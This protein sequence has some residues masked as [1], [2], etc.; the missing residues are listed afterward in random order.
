MSKYHFF[1]YSPLAI[2][3]ALLTSPYSYAN[4]SFVNAPEQIAV[5][6]DV[7]MGEWLA[8]K[9]NQS[10]T[11][12]YDEATVWLSVDEKQKQS[13]EQQVL[14]KNLQQFSTQKNKQS[15]QPLVQWISQ[16]P[17]TGRVL[18]PNQDPYYLQT[19]PSLDPVFKQGDQVHLYQ[20]PNVVSVL[21]DD[22]TAC[23]VHYEAGANAQDYIK[24]CLTQLKHNYTSDVAYLI[25]ANGQVEKLNIAHWNAKTA[26][27]I[28][29]GA[30]IWV[31]KREHRWSNDLAQRVANSIAYQGIALALPY[32]QNE[33]P[34]Q[35]TQSKNQ[36]RDLPVSASDWG[37][38]G[39][40]QTPTAR[41]QKTGT[42]GLHIAHIDPYTNY[43]I[44]LQPFERLEVAM[45][46]TNIDGVSYGRVSPDQDYKDKSLDVKLKLLKESRWT[47]EVAV[48][49]R[50]PVGTSLFGGE[51]VVAN[52]RWK[53]FDFSLGLGWGYLGHRGN[54]DNPLG[55]VANR[56]KDRTKATVGQGGEASIDT[57]FTGPTSLFGGVQWHSP[58]QPLSVKVEYDGNDY[59]NEAHGKKYEADLPVNFGLTWQGRHAEVNAGFERGNTW[60][61]GVALRGDLT[62]LGQYK[63][64]TVPLSQQK[65]FNASGLAYSVALGKLP[66]DLSD[67][68]K[69]LE[70]FS[71]ETNWKASELSYQNGVLLIKAEDD[72]GEFVNERL[73]KG[74]EV[75]NHIAPADTKL[76]TIQLHRYG[77]PI[78]DF[79]IRPA[80]WKAQNKQLLPTVK[81]VAQPFAQTNATH[82]KTPTNATV[83]KVSLPK[84][85]VSVSPS[86]SQS[87]GGP[88][89]YILGVFANANANY[90]LWQGAWLNGTA[91]VRI[92]DNY[93]SYNFNGFS[94]LPQVRTNI[95]KYMTT[96]RVLMPNLQLTQFKQFGQ[97]LYGLAY[98]G[99]L[100]PMFAGVGGEVLY[101]PANKNWAI[102][103]DVN[104]VRQRDFDQHFG[105]QDYDVTTGHL[106]LYWNTNFY[107]I[108]AKLSVGQYLAGD[109]GA[110]LDLSR[111]F[112]N[113]VKMG[114]W[115]TKTN[116]SAEQFGEGSFDKGIYVSIPF[117]AIFKQWSSGSTKLVYQPLLRDGG[118]QINRA[119]T[120][121]DLTNTAGKRSL[122]IQNPLQS[123]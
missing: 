95:R 122:E 82:R 101:R 46:Y 66:K 86:I 121:Y 110:T 10:A 108:D 56:F 85:Y 76:I 5:A 99:Y 30:W 81:Q 39:L 79:S 23:R 80:E 12:Y 37:L 67:T 8:Q 106:S 21:F 77:V 48:G 61:L 118:A 64:P 27:A 50:D 52:K 41:M 102:G 49:W 53:D 17:V 105:L 34:I 11:A 4:S 32:G 28:Q 123:H 55:A 47:P 91:Q 57:W 3:I 43:N 63:K 7:R 26:S 97:G 45:R 89:G 25:Q 2:A 62:Q 93:D 60:M 94:N 70:A 103:L 115:A 59:K 100:D 104:Q 22:A 117:D 1:T 33:A 16:L 18:L 84:G 6:K 51:Y 72:G 44:V 42:A 74:S 88:D 73:N 87:I 58:Y 69:I 31:T 19:H 14:V 112:N 29:P 92:A 111:T 114:A 20:R 9:Q 24:S 109:R 90:K 15:I 40:L 96:S 113:G 35:L 78:T 75:L 68:Q 83:A 107:D 98:A 119:Y 120:L 116:V 65:Q 36:V 38:T 13:L 54:L 71:Q